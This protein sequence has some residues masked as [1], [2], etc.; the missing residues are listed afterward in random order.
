V[1]TVLQQLGD[2]VTHMGG[3]EPLANALKPLQ[4][5]A[6][7]WATLQQTVREQCANRD[8]KARSRALAIALWA[9][10]GDQQDVADEFYALAAGQ[11]PTADARIWTSWALDLFV[12]GNNRRATELFEKI[13]ELKLVTQ[14]EGELYFYLSAALALDAQYDR[15]L[16]AARE[17]ARTNPEFPAA[18]M[19]PAWVLY[20]ASRWPEARTAYETFLDR[21]ADQFG[22]P[23]VREAV[24]D[25]RLALSNIYLEL[26]Q[27]AGAEEQLEQILDEF[28]ED[29]GAWND[30]GY[31]WA[32]RGVHL[33]RALRMTQRAVEAEPDNDAYR[34]S[35]GWSLYRLERYDEAVEQLRHAVD[36]EQPDGIILDHL[37]D[38]LHKIGDNLG[39]VETWQRALQQIGDDDPPR[40]QAIEQKLKLFR[41]E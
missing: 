5:D 31:L 15:A 19:R 8:P 41:S 30:L 18:Q 24:R 2:A 13:L 22:S 6:E 21:Y 23:D 11:P 29:V 1:P 10:Q 25:A 36:P 37:G 40:R 9:L 17:A 7:L 32:E 20:L 33:Q 12:A 27:R 3:L 16:A 34:D 35:L 39:A 38:A 4:E 14:A 28:P 26:D